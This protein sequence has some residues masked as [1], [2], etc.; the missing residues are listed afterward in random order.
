MVCRSLD[1][2]AKSDSQD[3]CLSI[4][5]TRRGVLNRHKPDGRGYE[6]NRSAE[7]GQV[8]HANPL[9]IGGRGCCGNL[10]CVICPNFRPAATHPFHV[11]ALAVHCTAAS[12]FLMVLDYTRQASHNGRGC[13]QQQE[14]C[15]D[16][17]ETAHDSVQYN[18]ACLGIVWLEEAG[19]GQ[20]MVLTVTPSGNFSSN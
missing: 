3:G 4:Q 7:R 13:G 10:R 16:A 9:D 20:S 2:G 15:N 14:D 18:V 12:A 11:S 19:N 5:K 8:C 1:Q 6:V 17:G